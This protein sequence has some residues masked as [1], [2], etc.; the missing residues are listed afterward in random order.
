MQR[1]QFISTVGAAGLGATVFPHAWPAGALRA[2]YPRRLA[3]IGLE[4]YTVRNAMRRDPAGTLKRVREIGYDDVELLWSFDNFGQTPQQVKASLDALGLR[5]PSAHIDPKILL[6]DWD[7]SL[8]RAKFFGHEYLVVPS[9]PDDTHSLDVWRLWADRLNTAGAAARKAGVWLAFH[10]EAEHMTPI[11]GTVPYDLFVER[12]DPAAV[13]L[14]L[15]TGNML[16]GG[17]DP[18]AYLERLADRYWTFHLKDVVADHSRDTDLGRGVFDFRRFLAGIEQ[19]DQKPCYVEREQPADE[20]ASAR[21][22]CE[23]LKQLEF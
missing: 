20:L 16:L 18:F 3:H 12:T 4:L 14:Q 11:D 21:I 13:R 23:Y 7:R 5:A 17:G 9:L 1:R 6:Q 22:D 8:E 10:N 15:D 2:L 19:L